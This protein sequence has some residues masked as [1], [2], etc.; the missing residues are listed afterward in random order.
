MPN[1]G[2]LALWPSPPT[3]PTLRDVA[4]VVREGGAGALPAAERRADQA[5]YQAVHVK[6]ALARAQGMPFKWALNPYRGCTHACEYCYARKYQ[7]HLELGAGDDFSSLIFVKENLADVLRKELARRSWSREHVAVGTATD[8]YQPIEGRMTIT[9]RCLEALHASGTPFSITTKGPMVVR[10]IDVLKQAAR[11]AGCQVYLSVPTVDERAWAALEP[12]TAPP[13]QRLRAVRALTDA[14]ID[15][16]VLMMP[17]VPGITTT[18]AA[19]EQTLEAIH[20]TGARFVGANV[21]HLEVGVRDH[22]FA[23]LAREYPNLVDGYSQ[24]YRKAYAPPDYVRQ[25]KAM[26]STLLARVRLTASRRE[27]PSEPGPV[28]QSA[29]ASRTAS[30]SRRQTA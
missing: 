15:A 23:F 2:Q 30:Q 14:G 12:G 27:A 11:G 16:G 8:P 5:R 21:A 24:L 20:R 10:D 26:V 28:P 1:S 19:V 4:N 18:R 17:L 6:S 7:A 9:R 25:V 3:S 13:A 29:D 22:F